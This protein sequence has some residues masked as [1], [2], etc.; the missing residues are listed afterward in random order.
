[1]EPRE[2]DGLTQRDLARLAGKPQSTI[3][4]IA[5][6]AMSASVGLLTD[7]AAA[8]GRRRTAPPK[9]PPP[10][11]RAT[12]TARHPHCAPPARRATRAAR[13]AHGDFYPWRPDPLKL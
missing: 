8:T 10:A 6:G 2:A 9:T 7:I 13:P 5:S 4:R 1:M 3:A 12:R 11:P